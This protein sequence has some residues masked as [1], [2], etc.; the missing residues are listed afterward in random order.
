[1]TLEE[2]KT[3]RDALKTQIETAALKKEI[4]A[5]EAELTEIEKTGT[6]E[7]ADL[8]VEKTAVEMAK[9]A[10]DGNFEAFQKAY[11]DHGDLTIAS[12]LAAGEAKSAKRDVYFADAVK[13]AFGK[14]PSALSIAKQVAPVLPQLN[15]VA[16]MLGCDVTQ[17]KTFKN[18]FGQVSASD[19]DTAVKALEMQNAINVQV[20]TLTVAGSNAGLEYVPTV[21]NDQVFDRL[22]DTNAVLANLNVIDL[23]SNPWRNPIYTNIPTAYYVV[24]NSS[25][26][27]NSDPVTDAKDFDAR[28]IGAKMTY[29]GEFA[30]DSIIAALPFA[31]R[32]LVEAMGNA[33]ERVCLFGDTIATANNNINNIDGTPTTTSGAASVYLTRDGFVK[34]CFG[35]NGKNKDIS[36][37][38]VKGVAQLMQLMG[39]G[40]IDPRQLIGFVNVQAAFAYMGSTSLIT[41][42]KLGPNATLLSGMLGSI[43][44]MPLV[45]SSGLP[46][47]EASDGKISS[48]NTLLN[49]FGSLCI[50][51]KTGV[52]I[53]FRRRPQIQ[54]KLGLADTDVRAFVATARL[55]PKVLQPNAADRAATAYGYKIS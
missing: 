1:M 22:M 39:V 25:A 4:A 18:L 33:I 8:T 42:D 28:K 45:P 29:S 46:Q 34:N 41:W 19:L 13:K 37:D 35:S 38:I 14:N 55:D 43:F 44:G 27:G 11:N 15:Q 6:V 7:V 21:F 51:K 20:K 40:A 53:G 17:L 54:E 30:E 26:I 48:A 24:E 10:K 23:P 9:L 31:Q 49:T 2:M 5:S 36:A 52:A 47:T 16:V 12:K 50:V 32:V 3:K